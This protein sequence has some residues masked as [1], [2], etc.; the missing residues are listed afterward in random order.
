M[1]AL[2]VM[3]P[4][5]SSV[6]SGKDAVWNILKNMPRGAD[7]G[8]AC[9]ACIHVQ[10]NIFGLPIACDGGAV[11]GQL[12]YPIPDCLSYVRGSWFSDRP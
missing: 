4:R 10:Y 11:H 1:G 2:S 9:D 5:I 7:G 6:E 8:H 3:R 12:S